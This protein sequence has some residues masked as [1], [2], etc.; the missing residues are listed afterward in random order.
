MCK[1]LEL[2]NQARQV[3]NE[4]QKPIAAGRLKGYT[5][6]NP[7]W[8][9]KKLTELFGVCGVGWYTDIVR[10]WLDKGERETT[11]N[12]EIKLY[13]KV[14]GEWSKGISGI[15]ASKFINQEK[16]GAYDNDEC[17][18]CAYTDAMSV[19]CKQLGIGADV[20]FAKDTDK[21]SYGENTGSNSNAQQPPKQDP[22]KPHKEPKTGGNEP[23]MTVEEASA[24]VIDHELHKGEELGK[25]WKSDFASIPK[26]YETGSTDLRWAIDILNEAVKQSKAK[27]NE[28]N[29]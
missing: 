28:S 26:M 22:P 24:F 18:K 14:D 12:V 10:T 6:I 23:T 4:A 15:G 19:A 7:M 2:Y 8:R 3:P 9:I 13:I 1:N 27:K 11:A 5:D 21:Y 25:V 20:Y 17:Y 29:N 16:N